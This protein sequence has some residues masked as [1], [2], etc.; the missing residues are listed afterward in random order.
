MP[1]AKF[2]NALNAQAAIG[3]GFIENTRHFTIYGTALSLVQDVERDLSPL[4]TPV[5]LPAFAGESLEIVSDN[6]GDAGEVTV[7][8]LGPGCTLI[9][10]VVVNLNG[11]TPVPL[12]GALSRVN[13]AFGSDNAG[14]VGDLNIQGAGGGTV[15]ATVEADRQQTGQA[16]FTIEAG[17]SGVVGNLVGTMQKSLGTD[18][19]VLFSFLFKGAEQV[20]YRRPLE[21]GLQRDGATSI[22]LDNNFPLALRGPVDIKLAATSSANGADV[23]GFASGLIFSGV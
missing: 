14:F 5:P 11:L 17:A 3:A 6:A 1:V 10:P 16:V 18:T 20:K 15:F 4:T 12:P 19:D 22:V 7:I 8:A 13:F 2:N 9:A 21:F 23:A